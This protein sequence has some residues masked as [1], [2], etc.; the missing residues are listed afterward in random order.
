ML[1]LTLLP[2][3][4]WAAS[5]DVTVTCNPTTKAWGD[6]NGTLSVGTGNWQVAFSAS[7]P[8]DGKKA[9]K[10]LALLEI[11]ADYTYAAD[12]STWTVK[13]NGTNS[14]TEGADEFI[15]STINAGTLTVT[16]GTDISSM[17]A[18][19]PSATT[20]NGEK[21][22]LPGVKFNGTDI[23]N[24]MSDGHGGTWEINWTKGSDAVTFYEN[25]GT[26]T[27]TV[28][29]K[30]GSTTNGVGTATFVVGKGTNWFVSDA[31]LME[32]WTYEDGKYQTAPKND[33]T[34]GEAKWGEIEYEYST[35][36]TFT[37]VGDYATITASGKAGTYYVRAKVAD[38]ANG[39][40]DAIYGSAYAVLTIAQAELDV[41][42]PEN[43]SLVYTGS[44]QTV[45]PAVSE[46]TYNLHYV[47]SS[48]DYT[49]YKATDVFEATIGWWAES[50]NTNYKHKGS[51]ADPAGTFT[52]KIT[53]KDL[54]DDEITVTSYD[55]TKF[56][57]T[58]ATIPTNLKL[59]YGTI[60]LTK[61]VDWTLEI[62]FGDKTVGSAKY[63][64]HYV[65]TYTGIGN[66]KGER[67]VEFDVKKAELSVEKQSQTTTYGDPAKVAKDFYVVPTSGWNGE[68]DEEKAAIL[69]EAL[70][71]S[72]IPTP[73][74]AG[75]IDASTNTITVEAKAVDAADGA[76]NY[77]VKEVTGEAT[78]TIN[79]KNLVVSPS[80]TP[81]EKEFKG[82]AYG[83]N[84]ISADFYT[85][86]DWVTGETDE[87]KAAVG[88]KVEGISA[89]INVGEYPI[90]LS[91][92][93]AANSNYTP[94]IA[95]GT[96]QLKITAKELTAAM[97][98]DITGATYTG[99]KQEPTV[100]VTDGD[101]SIITAEDF[102]ITWDDDAFTAAKTYTASI[103]GKGNYYTTTPIEKTYVIS[104]AT[105]TW[106]E[107]KNEIALANK[108]YN[109]AFVAPTGLEAKFGDVVYKW[110]TNDGGTYDNVFDAE[111]GPVNAGTYYVKGFVA[112]D[113]DNY[114]ALW[115]DPVEFVI[116]PIALPE[117]FG[118]DY[119][120]EY[121]YDATAH[122]PTIEAGAVID[123]LEEGV[124][125]TYAYSDGDFK[126][127][128][129]YGIQFTGK[130]N[131][132]KEE[133]S[134]VN[135][136]TQIVK[137]NQKPLTDVMYTGNLTDSKVYNTENQKPELVLDDDAAEIV[138]ADY[139]VTITKDET[140]LA[141]DAEWID[142]G[143]YAY[144]FTAAETGNY[145]GTING[146][147]T[148]TNAQATVSEAPEA[149]TLSYNG[150]EQTLVA[151]PATV[152]GGTIQYI[153]SETTPDAKAKGW[154]ED[155]PVG[156]NAQS[157]GK[158][159]YQVVP[160]A[161]YDGIEPTEVGTAAITQ[162]QLIYQ[163]VNKSVTYSGEAATPENMYKLTSGALQNGEVL[164]ELATISFD[165]DEPL[166]NAGTYQVSNLDI[167]FGENPEN[168][169]VSFSNVANLTIKKYNIT[170]ADLK[171]EPTLATDLTFKKETA[172]SLLGEPAAELT[173]P[174][175]GT[176][177]YA[178]SET[179]EFTETLE[180]TDPD[181]YEVWYKIEAAD[182]DNYNDMPAAK[183]GEVEIANGSFAEIAGIP[184]KNGVYSGEFQNLK[185]TV[186]DENGDELV[187]GTDYN[188]FIFAG[189]TTVSAAKKAG[190]YTYKFEG[191]GNYEGAKDEKTWT[192]DK[193]PLTASM[194]TIAPDE[195]TYKGEVQFPTTYTVGDGTAMDPAKDVIPTVTY[196]S[197]Q[198]G[199][200]EEDITAA[201]V[202]GEYEV[203]NAGIYKVVLNANP[204][205]NYQDGEETVEAT[206]TINRAELNITAPT[207]IKTY[208]GEN[209]ANAEVIT[210]ITFEGLFD[211][212]V[213]EFEAY[214]DKWTYDPLAK[215]VG[216]YFTKVE[217]DA[218]ADLQNYVVNEVHDGVLTINK[219]A[220]ITVNF[221]EGK[222]FTKSYGVADKDAAF[223]IG[224]LALEGVADSDVDAIAGQVELT[225]KV[226]G[227]DVGTEIVP[228][229]KE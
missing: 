34:G 8:V 148:I 114:A 203:K 103:E 59:H 167:N 144:T 135:S 19:S 100:T 77:Y 81:V 20:Y 120:A 209:G 172:Q 223:E 96:G 73:N 228:Q 183:I 175:I 168:Y 42:A 95:A 170:T 69:A 56:V 125:F 57:Y 127:A 5:V 214:A 198:E 14:F 192:I 92:T 136:V 22:S 171:V 52:A 202:A 21:N 119:A 222:K 112:A 51:L 76:A 63:A 86:T 163:L 15:I 154:S 49:V 123:G 156:L 186:K 75:Y 176:I 26:Y 1:L 130:G 137:I 207:A 111:N 210:P 215:N 155:A 89:A 150:L 97:V 80:S 54:A 9:E 159:W 60:D 6:A 199:A 84:E 45:V 110:D 90:S 227:E 65:Y 216:G 28:S 161:N 221:A 138:A 195:V 174:E 99:S 142:A 108:E 48:T 128:G 141:N 82:S 196:Q 118:A 50:T 10:A 70:T 7:K 187:L 36:S 83:G 64:G 55:L 213:E 61:N 166:I 87:N 66:Y 208:D 40:Y 101:P 98:D 178:T 147:F 140:E 193:K 201:F 151:E 27:V 71:V 17:L 188:V 189:E 220:A 102:D 143:V 107:G 115:S 105:N 4:A 149:L 194:L 160:A 32:P 37:S 109:A 177:K 153:I 35:T 23:V 152:T 121:T 204:D 169:D 180:E 219:A 41:T 131:Y 126:H 44:E 116:N 78:Y 25:V 68:T 31:V 197:F 225:R 122:K 157:Y 67:V 184:E 13:T 46:T 47:V 162:V 104:S 191:A 30:N 158:V 91:A 29:N 117:N 18:V 38:D 190:T 132:A 33:P 85:T 226:E 106:K 146:T 164:E 2:F 205:G 58:N 79:K 24:G 72:G 93:P 224:T 212:D 181:T 182:A 217:E 53:A 145:T 124:D 113:G 229:H 206:Y 3:T 74:D 165:Y 12:G 133:E 129:E 185:F 211:A 200:T 134:V 16:P 218:F 139:T 173:V 62:K 94:L 88:I 43:V 11:A 179:G 39:N